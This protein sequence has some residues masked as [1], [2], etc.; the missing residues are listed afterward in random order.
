M[1]LQPKFGYCIITKTLNIA[2]CL[3]VGQNY[4]QRDKHLNGQTDDPITRCPR[5]TF[6]AGGIKIQ[7]STF[8][9]LLTWNIKLGNRKNMGN[10]K[11]I[12]LAYFHIYP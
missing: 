4:S 7:F 12:N 8:C 5:W 10:E 1:N 11:D 9:L 3:K 6:Q 2:L